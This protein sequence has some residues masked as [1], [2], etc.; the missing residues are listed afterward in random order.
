MFLSW[1]MK[2]VSRKRKK[3]IERKRGA[4]RKRDR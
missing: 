2:S 1:A 3:K 4:A